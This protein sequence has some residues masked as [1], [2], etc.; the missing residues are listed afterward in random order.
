MA[1]STAASIQFGMATPIQTMFIVEDAMT[2]LP[3][4]AV[5]RVQALL[6]ILDNIVFGKMVEAQDFL[7]AEKLGELTL[8]SADWGKTH[9]DLLER[10]LRRYAGYL[11]D[12]LGCPLYPF[13]RRFAGGA[14]S[15]G[16][17]RVSG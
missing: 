17:G 7:A 1:T 10:E 16:N 15:V 5:P 13:S 12:T 4:V 11:A 14:G 6:G 3:E 9:P 8:R 2:L